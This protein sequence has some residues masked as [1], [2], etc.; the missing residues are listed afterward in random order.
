MSVKKSSAVLICLA[1]FSIVGIEAYVFGGLADREQISQRTSNQTRSVL[2]EKARLH[3]QAIYAKGQEL[4]N[5]LS[6]AN[7]GSTKEQIF[8]GLNV[9]FG[10]RWSSISSGR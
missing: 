9:R 7:L 6:K 3:R 8:E 1:I 2:I 10:K 5:E 4:E